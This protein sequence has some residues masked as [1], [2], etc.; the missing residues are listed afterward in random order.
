MDYNKSE[1]IYID[2]NNKDVKNIILKLS[3]EYLSNYYTEDLIIKN[4][5][6]ISYTINKMIESLFNKLFNEE[7]NINYI[8]FEFYY[9]CL[10]YQ[11]ENFAVNI[12]TCNN[13]RFECSVPFDFIKYK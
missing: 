10:F 11:C 3:I 6:D 12:I 2:K 7:E 4:I 5:K 1:N 9:C 8:Y 13:R